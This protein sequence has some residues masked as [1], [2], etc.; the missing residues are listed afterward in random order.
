[1]SSMRPARPVWPGKPF[2]RRSQRFETPRCTNCDSKNT[3]VVIR[4]QYVLYVRCSD[5]AFGWSVSN[6]HYKRANRR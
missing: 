6:P 3:H 2:E 5:C 1:M 4:T